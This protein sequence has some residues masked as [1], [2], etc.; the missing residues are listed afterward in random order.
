MNINEYAQTQ[1]SKAE[2]SVTMNQLH[3]STLGVLS[4]CSLRKKTNYVDE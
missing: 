4:K 2:L 1:S 3:C